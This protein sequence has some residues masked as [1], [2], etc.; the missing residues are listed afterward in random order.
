MALDASAIPSQPVGAGTYVV[1]LVRV[2]AGPDAPPDLALTV[3]ARKG[4]G[5]RWRRL[6]P[7][8][9]V[10]DSVPASRPGRLAYEQAGMP[11]LLRL[12]CE[13]H[14]GPHY[15]MPLRS[16]VPSVVTVH[17]L[18]FFDHPEWHE[19]PKVRLFRAAIRLAARRAAALVCVS[20]A[21]AERLQELVRPHCPV[22]VVPHGIDH[23]R[24]HPR[25]SPE[26]AGV[27]RRLGL[28]EPFVLHLG[29]IEPRKN[30]PV[31][32][33]AFTSLAETQ[34]SLTLVV[35]GM[36]GWGVEPFRQAMAASRHRDRIVELGYVSAG[37]VPALL[38]RAAVVAYPSSEE[39]FGL[40]VLEALA[41][42]TPVVTSAGT[43][44]AE[45]AAGAALLAPAGDAPAL[46]EA[47]AGA[48]A[49]DEVR[50]AAGIA[51]AGRYSWQASAAAHA[52]I[53]RE[54]AGR[55]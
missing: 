46:A 37:D 26:D 10:I 38:R 27:L 18:T 52:A 8:A 16:P 4:D 2:L 43:V 22:H 47:L 14:H 36:P 7:S 41:C 29:T 3:L 23:D 19:P 32:V 40:P 15:T 53:Y 48:L 50:R 30:L 20:G 6:A 55:S 12:A 45:V 9:V 5:D 21:T 33:D 35:A 39:G 51:V 24:F 42:G 54:A 31:L 25:S 11:R 13:L 28:A 1:E 17:D 34:R 49:A 44:M